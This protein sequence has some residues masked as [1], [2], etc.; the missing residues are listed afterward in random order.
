MVK[1]VFH[2]VCPNCMGPISSSRL[3]RGLPCTSCLPEY[4]LDKLELHETVEEKRFTSIYRALAKNRL[5]A[6]SY[7]SNMFEELEI[8]ENLFAKSIGKKLWSLQR[9]WAIRLLSGESFAITAPT[10]VGKTTLLL[11]YAIYKSM[12]GSK[13]YILVPTDSLLT[14]TVEKLEKIKEKT[15]V[16]VNILYYKSR[17]SKKR[18]DETLSKIEKNEYD[19]LV[20]TTSF[21][22]RRYDIMK[23]K[24]FDVILVDDADSLL[25]NS[26]NI[27]RILVL[28]GFS[29][30]DV[31]NAFRLIKI[32]TEIMIHRI[33]N[34]VEKVEK[35]LPEY[36]RLE[37][38]ISKAKSEKKIGQLAIASATGRQN[39]IKPKLFRELLDFEIG[40]IHDYMRNIIEA[41]HLVGNKNEFFEKTL[42]IS[43]TLGSGGLIFVSRDMGASKAKELAEYL[44]RRGVKASIALAGKRVINK[45]VSGEVDVLV[46]VASYYGVIVRGI[47]LP[48]T[49]KYAIFVGVPKNRIGIEKALISPRRLLQA[50]IYLVEKDPSIESE[51][52][53][54]KRRLERL[55]P[56]EIMVL[57]I[58]FM[59][60][61]IEELGG[62]L[63]I[64]A[65]MMK[66]AMEKIITLLDE[67]IPEKPGSYISLGTGIVER[68]EDGKLY[69]ITPDPLTYIQ[70][71]GRTSRF[72]ND[73]MTLGL[74][75]ILEK[76]KAILEALEKRIRNYVLSF[77]P[78]PLE[79]LDLREVKK[80]LIDS[81]EKGVGSKQFKPA[82]AV[83]IVVESPNKARTIAGYFGRPSKRRFPGITAYE[84]PIIDPQTLDTYLAIIVATKGHLYDL[85]ID[86]GIGYYG[87]IPLEGTFIPVFAPI[88]RCMNCGTVFSSITRKCPRCGETSKIRSSTEIIQVLRKLA[89]E[90]D[91]ILVA[92]DPD[93]EGE[94]IAWDAALSIKP[95]NPNIRRIEF[96]EVTREA[97][98]KALRD[99]REI[100]IP[101]V[102][103]QVLR[104]IT[105]RWIGFSLSQLLW[106]IYGK[107]WLGA[108]RVQTPVLGWIIKRYTEWKE[109]QGYWLR[110]SGID[111]PTI[112]I[113][114]KEKEKALQSL[115]DIL[116]KGFIEIKDYKIIDSKTNPQP[117]LTTDDLLYESSRRF[118]YTAG[119]TM[120]LAQN[121]F[122]AGLITYHRTDSTRV[123][124]K[125]MGVAKEYFEKKLYEKDLYYPRKWSEGG[126]HEA[127]RPTRPMDTMEIR[128]SIIDGSLRIPVKLTES[129]YKLYDLIFKR[130]MASQARPSIIRKAVVRVAINGME[131]VFEAPIEET[132]KGH[133]SVMKTRMYPKLLEYVKR[134]K[135]PIDREKTTVYRGSLYRLYTQ[136]E[137]VREMKER[138]LGRPST[139]AKI[140][141]SIRRHGYVI[142]SKKQKYLIPTKTG[143]NVH[144]YL[145]SNYPILVSE[146]TTVELENNMK[147]IEKGETS[148]LTLLAK[149]STLLKNLNL[150]ASPDKIIG[151]DELPSGIMDEALA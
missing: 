70:A 145:V 101:R 146:N 7:L 36:E 41:Y 1:A 10:G 89:L 123:S 144:E 148:Y 67:N 116:N 142:L 126:A 132:V 119:Y 25:K 137:I 102:E 86:D 115:Q 28:S 21:L 35:L 130:F 24:K 32:K 111:S 107:R 143:I 122:E 20:T 90:T 83:L 33:N 75:I 105:D 3:E 93:T 58:A 48:K 37:L 50:M 59:K 109:G 96:H 52:K 22:S 60:N 113:Y 45:L 6:Y 78:K 46:G 74:S 71:S 82:K 98:I 149:L 112:R 97:I 72:L 76:N 49:V 125:G 124:P 94:K 81:R 16:K 141:E 127:I 134:G 66:E 121:L 27:D 77:K 80:K 2:G 84:T 135:I 30:E 61:N 64:I 106:N 110:I 120:K 92:T 4:N 26:K 15:G 129:H 19:I 8:F 140:V 40:G 151:Y 103:S 44:N 139:Y 91:E 56:N 34:N 100:N 79:D 150:L 95:Y 47:D 131:T 38:E 29:E 31:F 13:V 17:A 114:I 85:V 51:F 5:G 39:G 12:R 99:P 108:G 63:K 87:V 9:T 42:E 14:Q 62:K 128:K 57:R 88:N 54:L 147:K 104:R 133:L 23:E 43:K 136:G 68:G 138:G 11:H 18:R 69:M 117:P 73:R 53:D 55:T 65:E 118:G